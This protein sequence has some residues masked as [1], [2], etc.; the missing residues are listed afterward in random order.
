MTNDEIR[1]TKNIR[2]TFSSFPLTDGGQHAQ[3]GRL[4][5][6]V[7]ALRKRGTGIL[8]VAAT[9]FWE[10]TRLACCLRCPRRKP[11]FAH[12]TAQP[13]RCCCVLG[14]RSARRR[15]VHA[16]APALPRGATGVNPGPLLLNCCR[17]VAVQSGSSRLAHSP[18]A[19]PQ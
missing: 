19:S 13:H 9:L 10:H 12:G 5:Y 16:R 3:A 1:M 17:P 18:P 8:S 2:L 11:L 4:S 15:T 7:P 14:F 6:I